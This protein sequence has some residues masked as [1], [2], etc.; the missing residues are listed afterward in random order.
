MLQQHAMQIQEWLF[1]INNKQNFNII[2]VNVHNSPSKVFGSNANFL[3]HD[4]NWRFNIDML[5]QNST[6]INEFQNLMDKNLM[7]LE[8]KK[9]TRS[10]GSHTIS[11]GQMH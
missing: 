11:Y 1:I 9:I 2:F 3:S 6:Q 10:Y 5:D 4:S 7:E 8:F